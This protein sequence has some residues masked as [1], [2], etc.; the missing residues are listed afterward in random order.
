MMAVYDCEN[1]REVAADI[2]S[3]NSYGNLHRQFDAWLDRP[4]RNF[5]LCRS[6]GW[7]VRDSN[8][9]YYNYLLSITRLQVTE[10]VAA[11]RDQIKD[12]GRSILPL[13]V[14]TQP[15]SK[16]SKNFLTMHTKQKETGNGISCHRQ[17]V[18]L[19]KTCVV[20]DAVVHHR[21]RKGKKR[22]NSRGIL[23]G[24]GLR[25]A[26]NVNATMPRVIDLLRKI[27]SGIVQI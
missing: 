20:T 11:L 13:M 16:I 15:D 23:C 5:G 10:L 4:F 24:R 22:G 25:L 8:M 2:C 6:V 14:K 1:V 17:P 7:L 27:R 21:V 19:T 9:Y 12:Y 18:E 26:H 3:R